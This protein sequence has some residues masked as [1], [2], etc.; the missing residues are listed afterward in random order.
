MENKE[1]WKDVKGYEGRYQISNIGRIKSLER[2]KWS[3]TVYFKS[4]EII[5]SQSIKDG[6]YAC[7][8]LKK[9]ISPHR[10]VAIAFIPNPENKPCVNHINGIKTDNRVE[11]LEWVTY[12]EN[13]NHSDRI[14]LRNV[15]GENSPLAK[16]KMHEVLEIR[17]LHKKGDML[18]KDIARK[19]GVTAPA[20]SGIT[21]NI[22]WRDSI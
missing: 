14:G 8:F 21:R 7:S 20:I 15:K 13:V 6:Y 12:K 19:Y 9:F 10:L 16:L 11:N 17:E 4:K 1:I 3:G 22:R 5:L 2:D 18:Q